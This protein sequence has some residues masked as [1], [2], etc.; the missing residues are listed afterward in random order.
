MNLQEV[1]FTD[2]KI[3]AHEVAGDTMTLRFFDYEGSPLRIT[4]S[5]VTFSHLDLDCVGFAISDYKLTGCVGSHRL[6]L[7]DDEGIVI[8]RV[9]YASAT[10]AT[11]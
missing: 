8:F 6:E 2:G 4:F 11:D 1:I 3:V 5:G 10:Y 9:E 7:F